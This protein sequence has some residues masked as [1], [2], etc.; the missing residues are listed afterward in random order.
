MTGRGGSQ[1]GVLP[2][3][4]YCRPIAMMFRFHCPLA[5]RLPRPLQ[6]LVIVI[7]PLSLFFSCKPSPP[8]SCPP[9]PTE[10]NADTRLR[11]SSKEGNIQMPIPDG[12]SCPRRATYNVDGGPAPS[13]SSSSSLLSSSPFSSPLPPLL[14]VDCCLLLPPPSLL[15]PVSLWPPRSAAAAPPPPPPPRCLPPRCYQATATAAAVLLLRRVNCKSLG[16]H[17]K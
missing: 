9:P 14:L 16:C 17:G 1:L 6:S 15:L 7:V 13:F 10:K 12:E 8:S 11:N 5:L 3:H 4:P 2:C